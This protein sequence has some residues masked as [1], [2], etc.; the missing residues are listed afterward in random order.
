ME[1]FS[2]TRDMLHLSSTKSYKEAY[3]AQSMAKKN[4]R[5]QGSHLGIKTTTSVPALIPNE[6]SNMCINTLER[7]DPQII[8]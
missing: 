3:K 7:L 1:A 8:T 2:Q 6:S 4:I 5:S